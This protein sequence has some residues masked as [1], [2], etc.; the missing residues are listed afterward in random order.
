MRKVLVQTAHYAALLSGASAWRARRQGA[1]R[2]LTL[3]GVGDGEM[4]LRHFEALMRWLR[5]HASVI[6]LPAMVAAMRTGQAPS[7]PLEV[8]LTLDD[9]LANHYLIAYPLLY[10]LGLSATMFVCPRLIDQG[11]WLWNHEVRARWR[12]LEAGRREPLARELGASACDADSVVAWMK[13]LR[14]QARTDACERLRKGTPGFEPD[15]AE[16]AAYDP[17]TWEQ[18]RSMDPSCITIGSH[19]LSHP[20]LPLLDDE[21]LEQELRDSRSE[22]ELRLGR[23]V[24]LLC[25]PN[26]SFNARVRA[27]AARHYDAAFSTQEAFVRVPV[28]D[29]W[30]LPRIALSPDLALSVWRLHSP[31]A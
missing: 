31:Q 18:V 9:G 13:G 11:R 14:L 8:A 4:P 21:E 24:P 23:K 5:R 27:C 2:I 20:I 30:S 6:P 28:A 29:Y 25:Y 10:E 19:S 17:L 1:R 3:H 16:S 12:H 22:L 15:P 26:G 7:A